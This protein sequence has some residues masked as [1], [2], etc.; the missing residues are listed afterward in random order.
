MD[1]QGLACGDLRAE[2]KRAAG[3]RSDHVRSRNLRTSDANHHRVTFARST[4]HDRSLHGLRSG[5]LKRWRRTLAIEHRG[6]RTFRR[7]TKLESGS[8]SIPGKGI[9]RRWQGI[10]EDKISLPWTELCFY[11]RRY[12]DIAPRF[13]PEHIVVNRPERFSGGNHHLAIDNP[14]ALYAFPSGASDQFVRNL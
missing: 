12:G 10:P 14:S 2:E 1:R 13:E 7:Y 11:C 8:G 9:A 3:K 4:Q 5:V 6:K